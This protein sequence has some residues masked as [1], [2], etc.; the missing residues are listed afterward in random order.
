[1]FSAM[2]IFVHLREQSHKIGTTHISYM[3]KLRLGEF[4]HFPM[5]TRLANDKTDSNPC[6]LH[7]PTELVSSL[8]F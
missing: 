6:L 4:G 7:F 2:I 3:K 8:P 1:M 5:I